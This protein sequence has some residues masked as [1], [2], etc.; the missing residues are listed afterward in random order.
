MIIHKFVIHPSAT[1]MLNLPYGSE[2]LSVQNQ[3]ETLCAWVRIDDPREQSRIMHTLRIVMTGDEETYDTT[4]LRFLGTVQ[5][6][7]GSLVLHIFE[8]M[9]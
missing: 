4:N 2:I 7:Q 8:E 5:M 3:R 6:A 9:Q 1:Y